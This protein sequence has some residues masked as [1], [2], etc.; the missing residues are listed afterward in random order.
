[1]RIS[2]LMIVIAVFALAGAAAVGA[3]VLAVERIET[4]SKRQVETELGIAG[5]DWAQVSVDGLQVTLTG[6]APDEATRFRAVALA[7][8]VVDPTRV[9]DAIRVRP[10]KAVEPPRF[11]V[12]ILRNAEGV[13]LIG[14]VPSTT[15]RQAVIARIRAFAGDAP[16]TELTESAD[17]PVPAGWQAALHFALEALAQLPRSKISVAAD[18][19]AVTAI[20][21]SAAEKRRIEAALQAALPEGVRLSMD[22]SA[23]RPVVTPFTL[24]FL[25]DDA[26]ARFD[27]CT[28]RDEKGRA[29]ILAAARAA[30]LSGEASC[31]LALGAPSPRWP[32]A[33]EMAIGALARLGG[34]SVTFSD[35]DVTLVAR[36]TTPP[37]LFDTVVGELE[38]RLPPAFALHAVLPEP[39][40]TSAGLAGDDKPQFLATLS[41]EGLL[42]LRGRVPDQRIR[43]AVIGFSR[44]RFSGADVY[45]AMRVDPELPDGWPKRVLAALEALAHL[46]HGAVVVQPDYV[47]IRGTTTLE[48][49]KAEISRILSAELGEAENFAIE[50]RYVPPPEP[51]EALPSPQDCVDRIN[52]ILAAAKITFAPGSA[53][54]TPEAGDTLDRIAEAMRGCEHVPMEIGGHTDSQGRESMNLRLSQNRADAVLNA[55]LAR[56]VDTRNLSAKGYGETQPIA[57]NDTEEG[58]EANRRIEFRLI[59]AETAGDQ[60][61]AAEQEGAGQA[62]AASAAQQ[63]ARQ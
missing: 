62:D 32:E 7:G 43:D 38:S 6:T 58:R 8:K 33:V 51:D 63:E 55:L 59:V 48:E 54:I 3:A 19:V 57:P 46:E 4:G 1:M 39:V 2:Q 34:G 10:G 49:G 20:T 45:G 52:G 5:L 56:R 60:A 36:D 44:A 24:R 35:G 26:G 61:P 41:P 53:D 9:I 37:D 27:A 22:I 18:E 25:I 40:D 15:D 17:Y 47:E 11:S 21:A 28:A 13:S 30:G 16:V 14:L 23:P 50:V 31:T 29:R 42:Q 12:E